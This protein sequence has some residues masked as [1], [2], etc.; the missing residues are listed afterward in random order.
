MVPLWLFLGLLCGRSHA[1]R[2]GGRV[3]AVCQGAHPAL[4]GS[5]VASREA[6]RKNNLE[7]RRRAQAGGERTRPRAQVFGR[8]KRLCSAR[9]WRERTGRAAAGRGVRRVPPPARAAPQCCPEHLGA[10]APTGSACSPAAR[11]RAQRRGDRARGGSCVGGGE[12]GAPSRPPTCPRLELPG[13]ARVPLAR[14]GAGR[15]PAGS[16]RRAQGRRRRRR[17]RG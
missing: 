12:R 2:T 4:P 3:T 6:F 10:P 7:D 8:H 9:S 11:I 1:G 17:E 16:A 13:G 5:A 14:Q 15:E